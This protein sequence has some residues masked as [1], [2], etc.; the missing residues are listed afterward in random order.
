MIFRYERYLCF[1]A[2]GGVEAISNRIE[3]VESHVQVGVIADDEPGRGF[4]PLILRGALS[5][6]PPKRL[7]VMPTVLV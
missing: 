1:S 4:E 3:L 6:G 2:S 5:P 7:F